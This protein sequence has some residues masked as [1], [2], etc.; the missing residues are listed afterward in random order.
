[1]SYLKWQMMISI[2]KDLKGVI[3]HMFNNKTEKNMDIRRE[4]KETGGTTRNGK[5]GDWMRLRSQEG[6]Q[7][8][9][10]QNLKTAIEIS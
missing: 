2:Y 7:E 5:L 6:L 10:S 8:E 1:M 9:I 3:I 4:E